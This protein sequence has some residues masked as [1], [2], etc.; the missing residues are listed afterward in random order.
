MAEADA[1]DSG[2]EPPGLA[3]QAPSAAAVVPAVVLPSPSL[4]LPFEDSECKICYNYFDLDRRAPKL[5]ECLHT[6]CAECLHALHL[7]EERPWRVTCPVCRHRT[8]VPDC[9]IRALPCNTKAAARFPLCARADPLPQD[10]LPPHPPPLH[11]ALAALRRGDELSASAG[12]STSTSLGA[13]A[14]TPSSATTLSRDSVSVSVSVSRPGCRRLALAAGC[15]CVVFSFLAML[16]LLFVGLVFVHGHGGGGGGG[17]GGGSTSPTTSS[18]AGPVCLSVASV[19]AMVA[20]VVTWLLCWLKYRPE[21][22]T[23]AGR[24]SATSTASRRSA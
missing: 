8:R 11:P 15:A 20:V 22:E 10:A 24:A 13:G 17:G 4:A 3:P 9:R 21:R 2:S 12:T 7:R 16:V 5:L 19:L 1:A 23:G 14:S 18:S 6:F